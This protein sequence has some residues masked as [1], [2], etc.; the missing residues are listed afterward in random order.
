VIGSAFSVLVSIV[1]PCCVA[2]LVRG[3]SLGREPLPT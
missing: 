3:P 1:S 2:A